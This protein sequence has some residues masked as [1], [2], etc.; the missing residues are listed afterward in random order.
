MTYWLNLS[1]VETLNL[2]LGK[3]VFHSSKLLPGL[4][5]GLKINP[6][7]YR[8]EQWPRGSV[9]VPSKKVNF[10]RPKT[11]TRSTYNS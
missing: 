4:E 1:V 3:P 11:R 6:F 10:I 5:P 8:S 2:G 9:N 7:S